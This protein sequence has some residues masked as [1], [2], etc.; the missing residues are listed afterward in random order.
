MTKTTLPSPDAGEFFYL[1]L[2]FLLLFFAWGREFSSLGKLWRLGESAHHQFQGMVAT[3][4]YACGVQQR[5]WFQDC[6]I[7]TFKNCTICKKSFSV[8]IFSKNGHQQVKFENSMIS[9]R[10]SWQF[11]KNSWIT[12]EN[13]SLV[14]VCWVDPPMAKFL[15]LLNPPYFFLSR[16]QILAFWLDAERLSCAFP[17]CD[18]LYPST[19]F[20]AFS[21]P[22]N[23][24]PDHPHPLPRWE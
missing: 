15:F 14:S 1:Y 21:D 3:W 19:Y 13:I 9:K 16:V 2:I 5:K 10:S 11:T 6:P 23:H 24:L 8:D 22:K 18:A 4:F 17:P 7:E 20:S 12:I